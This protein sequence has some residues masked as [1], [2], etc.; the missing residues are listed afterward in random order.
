MNSYLKPDSKIP[1][2][3]RC[4]LNKLQ[5][6]LSESRCFV[7]SLEECE[8]LGKLSCFVLSLGEYEELSWYGLRLLKILKEENLEVPHNLQCLLLKLQDALQ[9][10]PFHYDRKNSEELLYGGLEL[11]GRLEADIL[12]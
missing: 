5:D 8:D 4:F 3:F 11:L 2:N 1:H 12:D 10:K 7:S 6:G 9:K